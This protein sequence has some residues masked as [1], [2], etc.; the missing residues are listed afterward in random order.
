M[1]SSSSDNNTASSCEDL[2]RGH[3][4]YE[5]SKRVE[6]SKRTYKAMRRGG[7]SD[8]RS[9]DNSGSSGSSESSG[10][11]RSSDGYLSSSFSNES[12]ETEHRHAR[13]RKRLDSEEMS[14]SSEESDSSKVKRRRKHVKRSRSDDSEKAKCRRKKRRKHK[15]DEEK[16]RRKER[17]KERKQLQKEEKIRGGTKSTMTV[18]ELKQ[19]RE[20]LMKKHFNYTDECNPFGDNTL[21][22]PFVWKLKNKY[23]KIKNDNKVKI[24]TNSLLQ[25]CVSKITEIEEVKKR[26][27]EREKEKALLE[28]Y[29]LQLEKQRNQINIKEY[30]EKEQLFFI[31]QQIQSSD[32]RISHNLL[33][34]V[35]IF[36][37]A[38]KMVNGE[39]VKNVYP[40]HYRA[41]FYSLLDGLK[42]SEL[43]NCVKQVQ[44]LISHDK[45]FNESKYEKYWSSLLFF[46][47]YYLD[48]LRTETDVLT[49]VNTPLD[50]K[51]NKKIELFFYKKS[52]DELVT[53]EEKVKKKIITNDGNNID[54]TYWNQ[55]LLKIPYFKAKYVLDSFYRK[56]CKR[57][58][59]PLLN[60][61]EHQRSQCSYEE[62]AYHDKGEEEEEKVKVSYECTS[63]IP[64]PFEQF[65]DD[66]GYMYTPEE[67]LH[68]RK[69]ITEVVV[70][71]MIRKVDVIHDE[72][73]EGR[74][75]SNREEG[76]EDQRIILKKLFAKEKEIYDNFVQRE[77]KK[78]M[79]EGII[80]KDI[81]YNT[82]ITNMLRNSMLVTRKPLYFN[83]IKTSFD[84]NKYNKTHYDYENTPPKYICGY[85][86]N[87]FYTNLLN[88]KEKPSW[89]LYPTEDESKVLI[90]FHGGVPYLDIA[91]K[92]VNAEWSYDKHRGFRNVFDRGILQLYFN[93]KKK[94]YR[95]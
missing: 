12:A 10:W 81:S 73:L 63:P 29:L 78:G 9:S 39:D 27:E 11:S 52:Y 19:E 82:T 59:F 77:R 61:E 16:R 25:N 89:K 87:I 62:D 22:T 75:F 53:Y 41:P 86:F 45:L 40:G 37:L 84:W 69:K 2:S 20:N 50:E 26:R 35:D 7:S 65:G 91:F 71:K 23:E 34:P 66:E 55:V 58:S 42:K 94:R 8:G 1:R 24:T 64:I 85:K 79:R 90:I 47:D 46:C 67:E 68:E 33:Q 3:R 57:V 83:R 38:I 95:R 93:F 32:H 28:D 5:H 72:N 14:K 43:E 4:H 60:Q 49:C 17:K 13:R 70:D 74:N 18:K 30:I 88:K 76:K 21:S 36:R 48:R 92:I 80:L 54:T 15:R 31:N 51:T 6:K 56:L 44:L